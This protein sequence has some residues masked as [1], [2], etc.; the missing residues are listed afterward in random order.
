MTEIERLQEEAEKLLDHF[1]SL[2]L[3]KRYHL[4]EKALK[5]DKRL[6]DIKKRRENLQSSLRFLSSA[7]RSQALKTCKELQEEY[8]SSPLYVNYLSC[9]EEVLKLIEPLTETK[10]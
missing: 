9:R 10:L 4:L 6:S 2:D 8:E 5:E 7:E 3:V 1:C